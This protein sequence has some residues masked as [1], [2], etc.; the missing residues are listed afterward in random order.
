ML[1]YLK[2]LKYWYSRHDIPY[3]YNI[4]WSLL[5]ISFLIIGLQ[6]M[7]LASDNSMKEMSKVKLEEQEL[8][9]WADAE[10]AYNRVI[11]P[12][13]VNMRTMRISYYNATGNRMSNGEYPKEGY[14]ATSDRTI[15]LGTKL[16]IGN[17]EYEVGDRTAKWVH[18]ERGDTIDIYLNMSD[19][20]LKEKGVQYKEVIFK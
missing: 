18:T 8:K 13:K 11:E 17:K 4:V 2:W 3:S 12:R 1:N 9:L 19:E 5:I 10:R 16:S 20:E 15:P 6:T 14:V 7:G